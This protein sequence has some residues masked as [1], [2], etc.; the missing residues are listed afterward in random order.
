MFS[1]LL[2]RGQHEINGRT[3]T[4]KFFLGTDYADFTD[5]KKPLKSL[6]INDITIVK[7]A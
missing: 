3:R 5:F 7:S 2:V 4:Y 1:F 6:Y